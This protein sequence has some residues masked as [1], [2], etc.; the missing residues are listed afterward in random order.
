MA[1]RAFKDRYY[2]QL[3]R[4]GRCLGSPRRLELLELLAQGERPVEELA[5]L[6]D[7]TA[8]ATSH[9]LIA[10]RQGGLVASRK[11]GL[12]VFYRLAD[13]GIFELVTAVRVVAERRLAD[14]ERVVRDHFD[15]SD[16]VE[17]V[18]RRELLRRSRAGDVVVIDVRPAP[19]YRAGH[20]P[21]AISAPI[22]DLPRMLGR[23]PKQ[24]EVVA[25]CRGPY[26][27]Y[28]HQ[29]VALMRRQGRKARRLE[30]GFP[31]WRAAG[32]PVETG[33]TT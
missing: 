24:K 13:D 25:Y 15:G 16:D 28:A 11:E 2:D 26:C 18:S 31:E 6:V 4:V 7:L 1:S 12:Y 21:G 22:D 5:T 20:I 29:A 23:L 32:L 8:A 30:D 14:L 19:E 33:V 27:V 9:H 10:L 3:A 17:A